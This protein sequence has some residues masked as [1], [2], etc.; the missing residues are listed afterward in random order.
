VGEWAHIVVIHEN[1]NQKIYINGEFSCE[2]SWG[3]YA[4]VAGK[5]E[6]WIGSAPNGET[7]FLGE[8]GEFELYNYAMTDEEI[9]E[10]YKNAL[11]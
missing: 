5:N 2:R 1:I 8:I 7:K 9:V 4:D 10:I 6:L 3:T 11:I